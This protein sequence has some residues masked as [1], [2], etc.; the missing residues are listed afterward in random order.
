MNYEYLFYV[1]EL[2]QKPEYGKE[3][4]RLND[5]LAPIFRLV[6][7]KLFCPKKDAS[8]TNLILALENPGRHIT[9]S[10]EDLEKENLNVLTALE[11]DFIIH[12]GFKIGD[13]IEDFLK[14]SAE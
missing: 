13:S 4:K 2:K 3:Q 7:G 14:K 8:Y 5:A 6:N 1:L 9:A 11:K 10:K 12:K